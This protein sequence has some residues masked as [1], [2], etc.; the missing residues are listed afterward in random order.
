MADE[1]MFTSALRAG[2]RA[3]PPIRTAVRSLRDFANRESRALVRMYRRHGD[4]VLQPYPTTFEDRY[5][6][7]FGALASRL[8]HISE[9]LIL[10][11]GCSDGSEV[12]SLRRWFPHA[13]IVGLDP[14][15]LMIAKARDHL[16]LH[17]DPGISYVEASSPNSLGDV[18]FDAILAMAV[19]RHGELERTLPASCAT[20]LPFDRFAR[21]VEALD[22]HL[23]PGGWLSVWNAHFRFADTQTAQ[24]YDAHALEYSRG[25]PQTLFYGPDN[26]RIDGVEYADILFRKRG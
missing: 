20:I 4:Q 14:N 12:R 7:V 5:P 23:K 26:R 21:A 2:L 24:N 17:P 22:R 6:A 9:P 25:E 16:S 13:K 10:S 19:F 1:N 11:Y 18:Q 15:A 3:V 8:S